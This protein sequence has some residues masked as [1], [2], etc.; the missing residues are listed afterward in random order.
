MAKTKTK[1]YFW[2]KFDKKFFDNFIHQASKER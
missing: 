1:V 2:L